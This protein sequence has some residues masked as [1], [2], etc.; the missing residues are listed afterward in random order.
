M[1]RWD[2]TPQDLVQIRR[3]KLKKLLVVYGIAGALVGISFG[4]YFSGAIC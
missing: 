3:S 4:L 2:Q 1:D